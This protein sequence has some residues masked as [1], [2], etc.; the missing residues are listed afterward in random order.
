[1]KRVAATESCHRRRI[2]IASNTAAT[3]QKSTSI[4]ILLQRQTVTKKKSRWFC[5]LEPLTSS[6]QRN[7]SLY[8]MCI[9]LN[10]IWVGESS[11]SGDGG[12]GEVVNIQSVCGVVNNDYRKK[13]LKHWSTTSS[14][15]GRI[16]PQVVCPA[17]AVHSV[18]RSCNERRLLCAFSEFR[19][20]THNLTPW[21][22]ATRMTA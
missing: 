14:S 8:Y 21:T 10:I 18:V 15:G 16:T 4:G 7:G 2:F 13:K 5:Y 19:F 6:I 12:G 9:I 22:C 1:M 3:G 11:G 17:A 20:Y